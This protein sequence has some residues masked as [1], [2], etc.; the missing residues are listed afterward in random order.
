VVGDDDTLIDDVA[1]FQARGWP[2]SRHDSL[3][4]VRMEFATDHAKRTTFVAVAVGT[5]TAQAAIEAVWQ[6]ASDIDLDLR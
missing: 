3:P 6:Q 5:Q 4:I 1:Y 2:T